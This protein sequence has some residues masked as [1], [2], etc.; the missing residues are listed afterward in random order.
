MYPIIKKLI[1]HPIEEHATTISPLKWT[2]AN[3]FFIV[4][5]RWIYDDY[6]DN[7]IF[8]KEVII[9]TTIQL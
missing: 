8:K 5:P 4:I 3:L 9:P 6:D 7:T 1:I 2:P